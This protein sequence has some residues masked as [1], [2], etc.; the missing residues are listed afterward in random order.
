MFGGSLVGNKIIQ[1]EYCGYAC[2]TDEVKKGLP[3][4]MDQVRCMEYVRGLII[5]RWD[6]FFDIIDAGIKPLYREHLVTHHFPRLIN[7][8]EMASQIP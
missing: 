7:H 4:R 8:V 2:F 1:K 3:L 5:Q 6:Y